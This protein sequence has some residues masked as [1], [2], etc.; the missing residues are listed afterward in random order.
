MDE[1]RR[2]RYEIVDHVRLM[3][4]SKDTSVKKTVVQT[5][6]E[7]AQEEFKQET[8]KELKAKGLYKGPMKYLC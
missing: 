5:V 6:S 2:K 8:M 1:D 3:Q 7:K 4:G